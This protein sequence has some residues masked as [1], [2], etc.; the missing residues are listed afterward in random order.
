MKS[1]LRTDIIFE[2]DK[3]YYFRDPLFRFWIA[4]TQL[5][6]DIVLERDTMSADDYISDLKE[7]SLRVSTEL[8]RAV[9]TECAYYLEK[10]F[11]ITLSRYLTGDIEFDLVGIKAPIRIQLGPRCTRGLGAGG[12]PEIGERAAHESREEPVIDLL[13]ISAMDRDTEV[14]WVRKERDWLERATVAGRRREPRRDAGPS[15]RCRRYRQRRARGS[16]A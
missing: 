7:K 14:S 9:E 5:G 8:G 16:I 12:T 2:H 1:L 3:K 11:N 13:A 6:K 10:K 15:A 4:K